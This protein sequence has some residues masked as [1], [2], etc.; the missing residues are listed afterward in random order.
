MA[1]AETEVIVQQREHPEP[2]IRVAAVA[3]VL[4]MPQIMEAVVETAV[5]EL[6]WF[7][8]QFLQGKQQL[9]ALR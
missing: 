3:V 4:G 5:R 7:V 6:S 9:L 8:T 2:K 1:E